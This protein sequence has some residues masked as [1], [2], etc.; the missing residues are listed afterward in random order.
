[1]F[2]RPAGSWHVRTAAAERRPATSAQTV[3]VTHEKGR[4]SDPNG[5]HVQAKEILI[6]DRFRDL[7]NDAD[8]GVFQN[9][10]WIG[11]GFSFLRIKRHTVVP[12]TQNNVMRVKGSAQR[13]ITA[14]T[15]YMIGTKRPSMIR[16][17]SVSLCRKRTA[18]RFSSRRSDRA[19]LSRARLALKKPRGL[20]V[21]GFI[22]CAG[23]GIDGYL[24]L[25]K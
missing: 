5:Q 19:E 7:I 6:F 12:D 20:T 3:K 13:I 16:I 14:E 9:V 1:M 15:A 10:I 8:T 22:L 17:T 4:S 18:E 2:H 25:T 21:S 23:H 24:L 11:Q